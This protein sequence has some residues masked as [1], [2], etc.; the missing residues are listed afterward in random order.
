MNNS[1]GF[2]K[3]EAIVFE[4]DYKSWLSAYGHKIEI[5][6]SVRRRRAI[7][8]LEGKDP[9]I[10]YPID[11]IKQQAFLNQLNNQGKTK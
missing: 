10:L 6:Y 4:Q 3:I 8:V 11:I 2:S 5:P 1:I 9:N 7:A